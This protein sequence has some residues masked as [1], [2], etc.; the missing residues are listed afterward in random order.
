MRARQP[1]VPHEAIDRGGPRLLLRPVVDVATRDVPARSVE[2]G[3]AAHPL[4]VRR[5]PRSVARAPFAR[6][7]SAR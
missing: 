7:E 6:T 4:G 2:R 5:N 3:R 1:E